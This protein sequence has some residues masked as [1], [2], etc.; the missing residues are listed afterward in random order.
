M[1]NDSKSPFA[2]RL[3]RRQLLRGAAG[4]VALAGTAHLLP[5]A[6][7]A[8]DRAP[9][10][11]W[12]TINPASLQGWDLV[13]E[14]ADSSTFTLRPK[15]AKGV[16]KKALVLFVKPSPP[17]DVTTD[18]ILD[19]L[20]RKQAPISLTFMKF[21][22]GASL[23]RALAFGEEERFD[24]VAPMGSEA[25]EVVREAYEGGRLPTVSLFTKDPVLMGWVKGVEQGSGTNMAYCTNAVP[26]EV[27]LSYLQRLRDGVKNV[28]VLYATTS[29]STVEAQVEPLKQQADAYGFKIHDVVVNNVNDPRPELDAAMPLVLAKMKESD[30]TLGRSVFWAT[31]TTSVLNG[32]SRIA[33]RAGPVPVL[34]VYPD[35]VREGPG[36]ALLSIGVTYDNMGYLAGKYLIDIIFRDQHPTKLPVGVVSPPDVAIS[37]LKASEIGLRVP[38]DVFETASRVY[39]RRGRIVRLDGRIVKTS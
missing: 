34:S 30:P 39:D 2:A 38:F 29:R 10:V 27:Q 11:D 1:N 28:A 22:A 24:V 31:G 7:A 15:D 8:A 6:A 18:K 21:E 17:F 35:V 36:S 20:Q 16:L 3:G 26:I 4:A 19:V 23:K 12:V 33:E 13:D 9:K 32:M 25:T 14:A 37:F 5:Q